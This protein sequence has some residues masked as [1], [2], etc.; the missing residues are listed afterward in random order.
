[1]V[2]SQEHLGSVSKHSPKLFKKE[3]RLGN[4]SELFVSPLTISFP[5]YSHIVNFF[6]C[7]FLSICNF[8]SQTSHLPA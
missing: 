1:M 5:H 7:D 2:G 3:G 8:L 4:L 6:L